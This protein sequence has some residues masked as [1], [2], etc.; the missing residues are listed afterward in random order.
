MSPPHRSR[1]QDNRIDVAVAC[2][3]PS[4]SGGYWLGSGS[5]IYRLER[6]RLSTRL[7]PLPSGVAELSFLREDGQGYLWAGG[8]G[9]VYRWET[10]G[11]PPSG[12]WQQFSSET[13]L[14]DSHVTCLFRDREGS[15]WVGTGQRGLY[16]FRPHVFHVY[17]TEAGMNSDVVTSVTQDPQ[18]RMWLGVNGGGLH[19]WASGRL[20]PVT[21]PAAYGR[22]RLRIPCWPIATTR[23][24]SGFMGK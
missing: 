1:E 17:H 19:E 5:G 2:A 24:G 20:K 12:L 14:A 4:Q 6:G 18:G 21:E 16:R 9:K 23:S 3:A 15:L 8:S 10:G 13:G 22:I 11:F 7:V